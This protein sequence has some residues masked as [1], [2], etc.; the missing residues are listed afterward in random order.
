MLNEAGLGCTVSSQSPSPIQNHRYTLENITMHREL[1]TLLLESL[2]VPQISSC[3]SQSPSL[4]DGKT[5]CAEGNV[6]VTPSFDSVHI[7]CK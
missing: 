1:L 4:W 7:K 5:L 6:S 3:L 2:M